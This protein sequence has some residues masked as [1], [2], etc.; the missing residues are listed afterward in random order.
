MNFRTLT[1]IQI[2]API[3]TPEQTQRHREQANIGWP[4]VNGVSTA[5]TYGQA[6][7]DS[8]MCGKWKV[9]AFS[10][11]LTLT[12]H[13]QVL[14]DLLDVWRREGDNKV[15]IFTKSVKLLEMLEHRLKESS[16]FFL[17]LLCFLSSQ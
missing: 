3:D 5:P 13:L 14:K 6:V 7:F 9:R 2:P 11:S 16:K 12:N 8:R 10:R 1:F 17:I 15:L 4:L